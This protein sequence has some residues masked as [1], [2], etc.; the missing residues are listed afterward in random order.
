MIVGIYDRPREDETELTLL[1]WTEWCHQVIH[2]SIQV[3]I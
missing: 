2:G 1:T 3:N